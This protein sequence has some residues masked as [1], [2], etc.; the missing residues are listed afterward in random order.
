MTA[1]TTITLMH[2]PDGIARLTLNRPERH[3]ALDA[4][5]I[6]ELTEAARELSLAPG[7]RALVLTGKGSSFCAG[8]DLGWMRRQLEASP[9][10]RAGEAQSLAAMLRA[11]D[12]LPLLVMAAIEGAAY[13]G[14]VGLAA[15][16]DLVIA[17]PAARFALTETRLGLIPATI[18][19]YLQ[20][21]IGAAALRRHALHG[22]PF[23]AEE[24]KL[25]G[26]VADIAAAGVAEAVDAHLARVLA[27]A[28]GAVGEAKRLF[29]EIA[30]GTAGEAE[31]VAA[32]A[33]RW[34]SAEA[35][36]GIAAFFRKEKAPWQH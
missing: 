34:S 17:G 27:C 31:T 33:R 32:L 10:E 24:A 25:M 21:R 30:A 3:N 12:E 28:P 36:A 13:G 8:A 26:L 19:P 29:R 9:A 16:C 6:A 4:T 2:G 18:A 22:L 14:G 11:I 23:G 7:T 15:V 20:R 35:A 5:M 1:F